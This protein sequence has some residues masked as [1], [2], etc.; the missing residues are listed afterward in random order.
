MPGA[1]ITSSYLCLRC[2]RASQHAL[3][4]TST[5]TSPPARSRRCLSASPQLLR[6]SST[7][8][9]ERGHERDAPATIK[10]Q[11]E[12]GN[13]P[14]STAPTTAT[15]STTKKEGEDVE[16]GAAAAATAAAKEPGAMSR[17][18]EALTEEGLEAGGRGGARRAA[19]MV[20]DAGFSEELRQRLEE[21][22]AGANFASRYAQP[23]AQAGLPPGAGKGTRDLAG[24]RPWTGAES[25]EDASLRMLDD[26][27]RPMK[28]AVPRNPAVRPPSRVDTG[29]SAASGRG[30]NRGVR[31]AEAKERTGLYHLQKDGEGMSEDEREKLRREMRERFQ[32]GAR[33]GPM[34]VRALEGMANQ[35]IEDAIARGQFKN[36]PRGRKLERDYNASNPFLDTTEYFMNKIIQKQEIVPPWIEKQQELVTAAARFRNRLRTD[37]KRHAARMLSSEGGSLEMQIRR[38]QS[39]AEAE[40]LANPRKRKEEKITA[41][42]TEGHL[43]QITLAG[44]LKVP[45]APESHSSSQPPE[46]ITVKATTVGSTDGK[47]ASPRQ[48]AEE[49]IDEFMVENPGPSPPTTTTE[50]SS[51]APRVIPAPYPFRD[52][53]WVNSERSFLELSIKSLN[54]LT[55]SYN[56]MAPELAKKPYFSL[57]RE[58]AAAFADVAPQLPGE[59]RDRALEPKGKSLGGGAAG[60]GAGIMDHFGTEQKVN[61]WDDMR[62]V[63]GFRQL[64][65]DLF[66]KKNKKNKGAE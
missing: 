32:P 1:T 7:S 17:R 65:R 56:L 12:A 40:K 11:T 47:A 62:Q 34:S 51:S 52:P 31:L 23:L 13:G 6:S 28:K 22:I 59:I 42:D 8:A 66:P 41:V 9:Q 50:G 54:A 10:H 21:R 3:T 33:G 43:S 53:A 44:E 36:I 16:A 20:E 35:R 61:I 57:D 4:R 30:E 24:A 19:A 48:D 27:V 64:W 60:R 55:R 25:V 2:L 49:L 5:I 14:P 46:K 15:T 29:M 45:A 18:L 26:A 58:L 37:W 38:A 39:Y 63:Y